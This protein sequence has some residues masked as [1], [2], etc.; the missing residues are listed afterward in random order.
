MK[1]YFLILFSSISI[2]SFSQNFESRD[3][4]FKVKSAVDPVSRMTIPYES[5]SIDLL[6]KSQ[7]VVINYQDRSDTIP[8]QSKEL[9]LGSDGGI[10]HGYL[11]GQYY[12]ITFIKLDDSR[13]YG[14]IECVVLNKRINYLLKLN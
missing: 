2:F 8:I 6:I 1:N 12:S 5:K 11:G 10:Y 3:Y 14:H 7:I 4:S 13:Y 9:V